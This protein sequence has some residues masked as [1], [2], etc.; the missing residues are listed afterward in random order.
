MS[1]TIKRE[2]FSLVEMIIVIAIMGILTGGVALSYNMIREVDTKG[3]AYDIDNELT[4][5]KSRNMAGNKPIYMHLY[6]YSGSYYIAYSDSMTFTATTEAKKIGEEG[7]Q[8]SYKE[9][10]GSISPV[11]MLHIGIQK[12]DGAYIQAPE[13]IIVTAKKAS[14]YTLQLIKDT[15]KHYV[16]E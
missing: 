7:V 6:Q 10:S 4:E 13:E 2:A 14:T 16:E 5:L 9:E 3:A 8:I 15:G 1:D 12:K 11:T